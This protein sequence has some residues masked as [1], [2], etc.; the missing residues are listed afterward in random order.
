[1]F[2]FTEL[3]KIDRNGM[4]EVQLSIVVNIKGLEELQEFLDDQE[5]TMMLEDLDNPNIRF[6][7]S[8]VDNWYGGD[9]LLDE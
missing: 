3:N 7:G 2:G 6:L 9:V 5:I 1:M 4:L 8:F